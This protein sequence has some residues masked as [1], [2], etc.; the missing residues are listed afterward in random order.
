MAGRRVRRPMSNSKVTGQLPRER[1]IMG[2][3]KVPSLWL[4]RCRMW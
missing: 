1:G 2:N 3:T 4:L